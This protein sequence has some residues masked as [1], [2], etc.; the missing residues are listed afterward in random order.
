M[1]ETAVKHP[2]SKPSPAASNKL[3]EPIQV[4]LYQKYGRDLLLIQGVARDSAERK[5]VCDISLTM[6]QQV[7]ALPKADASVVL[8]SLLSNG[9]GEQKEKP[10]QPAV[11]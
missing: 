2:Q 6:F 10:E 7:V 8:R 1:V 11:P 9:E 5:K 3:L 4:S